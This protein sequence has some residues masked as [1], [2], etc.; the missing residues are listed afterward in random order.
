MRALGV[1][2]ARHASTRFP[3]KPLAPI[4]GRPMIQHVWERCMQATELD[5]L[6]VA[7][8]HEQIAACVRSFGG[9]AVMTRA[10]HPS[11]SD[12]MVE[13]AESDPAEILVNIQGDEPL[14]P[15]GLI[16]GLV[17]HLRDS[18]DCGCATAST[19]FR[20]LEE[21]E[22]PDAVKIVLGTGGR[23]LYFSRA[24]IPFPRNGEA[25]LEEYH[26]HIGIYAFRREALL[27]FP[28]LSSR[29]EGI[30]CLEQLRLLQNGLRID[31]IRGDW[32]PRGVDRPEDIAAV[33]EILRRDSKE[34][35]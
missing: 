22:S 29:A 27:A 21:L 1:I 14:I 19:A 17:R 18:G 25:D 32:Q 34:R 35:G 33:E 23:A 4:L 9:R 2:P 20:D 26:K 28:G 3:A 5:E 31:V 15:P 7:T 30:E 8:D 16:D 12:R 13:V 11:G 10:D 24:V 6:V